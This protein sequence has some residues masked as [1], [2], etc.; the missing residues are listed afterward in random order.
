MKIRVVRP[1]LPQ[2]EGNVKREKSGAWM[3]LSDFHSPVFISDD[4][5]PNYTRGGMRSV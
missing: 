3:K 2:F 4:D 1:K 5:V